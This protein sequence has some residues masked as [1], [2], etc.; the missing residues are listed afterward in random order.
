[1]TP[2]EFNALSDEEKATFLLSI[3]D[4]T[5]QIGDLTAERDSFKAEN[6]TLLKSINE[7][8][9]EL[10]ATKELNFSLARKITAAPKEDAET[11][12]YNFMK[13]FK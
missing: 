3:E 10:K 1:M 8:T 2:E 11:T 9:K 12:L 13:G 4:Q 6:A 7:T 5:K